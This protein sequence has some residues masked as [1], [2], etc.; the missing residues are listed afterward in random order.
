MAIDDGRVAWRPI[1]P[2]D[3]AAW[4]DLLGGIRTTDRSW[5]YLTEGD[6]LEEFDDPDRDFARGSVGVHDGAVMVGYGVLHLRTSVEPVHEIRWDGGVHPDYR[7]RGIG[8]RLL[9]WAESAARHL[10]EERFPGRALVVS[11]TCMS[12]NSD[13][14]AL[15]NACGFRP[16]RWFHAMELDLA[17]ELPNTP[18]PA[19]VEFVAL[20][21]ERFSDALRIRNEAFRDHWGSTETTSE[22]WAHYMG[23]GVYRPNLS[24]LASQSGQAL[25]FVISHEYDAYNA[26]AGIRDVYIARVGTLRT[27]RGRGIGT[28]LMTRVLTEARSTGFRQASLG[29]DVDSLTGAVGVYERLGFVTAHTSITQTKHVSA[30]SPHKP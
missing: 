1:G 4:A 20:T 28:A 10:H 7:G 15:Y 16:A 2:A 24:F 23:S 6:L 27:A 14:V 12:H 30:A 17:A 26:D 18:A 9:E 13:A 5:D 29:V 21:A 3:A 8:G 25:G 22:A 11:G 19:G